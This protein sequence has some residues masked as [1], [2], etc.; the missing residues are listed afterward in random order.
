MLGY[1]LRLALKSFRRNPGITALM[2]IAIALGIAGCVMTLTVYHAMSGN[3]IWW[4]NDRL[5]AVTMDNWDP[6]HP[7]MP[8]SDL[9]PPEMTYKDTQFLLASNIP[10]RKV[11]M[12]STLGVIS[13][14]GTEPPAQIATRV[15]T[16]D[17]FAMFEAPFLYGNGWSGG[18]DKPPQPLIVLSRAANDK[19]FG[20]ANSVG[21]TL[22]WNDQEFRII[23][24]LNDWFP[25]P[26]YY[27]LNGGSFQIPDDAYIPYG[28]GSDLQL[29]NQEENDC[30]K[31][32]KLDNYRDYEAS[33][34]V[35]QQMWV[36]LPDSASRERFQSLMDGYW[37]EQRQGGRFP[38]PKNNRLTDVS[39]WLRDNQVVDNDNRVLVGL[40]F[41]F[42][43]LCLINTVGLLL[44]KFLNGAAVTGIR[45]ALGASRRQIFAQLLLEVAVVSVLGALLGLALASLGLIAVR[46]MYAV[47][48]LADAHLGHHGGYEELTHFD[49]V[50]VV[51]AV[52]LAVVATLVAGFYPAWRIGRLSP[53]VY[54]K[55]Q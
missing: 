36:E 4:K 13:G 45:R 2:V 19:L 38:R 20:G 32:E 35:W 7:L 51:W 39:Q 26:R 41:A 22:R 18:A 30:W 10:L 25:R 33:D 29:L 42:L 47:A 44:A 53:A 31:P 17:F 46:H 49:V 12:Y 23:G 14:A 40:A 5:Y 9:P 6:Y 1:Y 43:A 27:D 3:P 8:N 50:G 54:L 15:T 16:A 48:H 24:V 21:R 55:S 34:C 28:W 11:V 37:A 52:I